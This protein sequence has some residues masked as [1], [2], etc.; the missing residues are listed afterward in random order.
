M[1]D[2]RADDQVQRD[3][4]DHQ[5]EQDEEEEDREIDHGREHTRVRYNRLA[6]ARTVCQHSRRDGQSGQPHERQNA[7]EEGS[8]EEHEGDGPS[9]AHEQV[10]QHDHERTLRLL[11]R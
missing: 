8:S 7:A 6:T 5:P 2:R 3:R 1:L 11:L 4:D 9:R 10:Q